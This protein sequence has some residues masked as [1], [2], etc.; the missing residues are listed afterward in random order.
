MLMLLLLRFPLRFQLQLQLHGR[1]VALL[2]STREGASTVTA[3]V[4]RPTHGGASGWKAEMAML[5]LLLLWFQL[6]FQLQLQLQRSQKTCARS[7]SVSTRSSCAC[8]IQLRLTRR[9]SLSCARSTLRL[10]ASMLMCPSSV[11]RQIKLQLN[12][13]MLTMSYGCCWRPRGTATSC[14]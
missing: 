7:C 11:Q 3:R 4:T 5:M 14:A 6:W 13:S 12:A 10:H 2:N 9:C 8:Q 1:A